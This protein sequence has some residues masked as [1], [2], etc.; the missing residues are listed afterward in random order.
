MVGL[1]NT[2][3]IPAGF[4]AHHQPVA[5]GAMTAECVIT[6][7]DTTSPPAAYNPATGRTAYP[8]AA[9]VHAGPCRVQRQ[10]RS[11]ENAHNVGARSV[12]SRRYLV[13]LP[14]A[15]PQIRVNDIVTITGATD[16]QTVGKTLRVTDVRGGSIL[17]QHD[18]ACEEWEPTT[19]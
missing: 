8:P 9:T 10:T 6:R 15:A 16:A 17:W 11:Q 5:A 13:S 19:R 3:V 4:E 18:L 1:V 7:L 14:V 12:T 2:H